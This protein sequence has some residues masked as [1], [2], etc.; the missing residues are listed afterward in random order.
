ML[1]SAGIS[2][3][4]RPADIEEVAEGTPTSQVLQIAMKKAQATHA[5]AEGGCILAADTMV[6]VD[7]KEGV[8]VLLGKPAHPAEAKQMLSALQ[9]RDHRVITGFVILFGEDCYREAVE[10]R[11]RMTALRPS[12]IDSYVATEEPFGKAG[13]YAI[14]GY[15]AAFIESLEGSYTNVVGLPLAEVRKALKMIG[16]W[17]GI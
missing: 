1:E 8:P 7:S 5:V 2:V 16:F 11:V 9:G 17:T 12:E 10:T 15:A 14:Q 4:V 6:V 13:A 3:E